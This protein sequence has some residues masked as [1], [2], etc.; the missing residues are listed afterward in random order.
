MT[1]TPHSETVEALHAC[2]CRFMDFNMPLTFSVRH[3]WERWVVEGFRLEDLQLVMKRWSFKVAKGTDAGVMRL[4]RITDPIVFSEDLALAHAERRI[5]Q[6][7]SAKDKALGELR[8]NAVEPR[9]NGVNVT[10][11]K[12]AA[13]RALE[14]MRKEIGGN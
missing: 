1:P 5:K 11:G 3:Q 7:P 2:Y 4:S 12:E 13:L 6:G 9:N 10:T 14:Q 8:P